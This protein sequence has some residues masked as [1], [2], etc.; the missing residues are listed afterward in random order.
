M[1]LRERIALAMAKEARNMVRKIVP[2]HAYIVLAEKTHIH[3]SIEVHFPTLHF[4]CNTSVA[5]VLTDSALST[6]CTPDQHFFV[7]H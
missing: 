5:H 7:L 2:Q 4:Y 6:C 3:S 1:I